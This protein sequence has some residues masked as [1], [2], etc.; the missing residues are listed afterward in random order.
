MNIV[1]VVH[2]LFPHITGTDV[3]AYEQAKRYV[4]LGHSVTMVSSNLHH[5][6]PEE[7]KDGIMIRRVWAANFLER[8]G[9]PYPLFSPALFTVLRRIIKQAD[10]VHV[11]GMLY[12]SSIIAIR[13]AKFY[14][15]PVVLTQTAPDK[16]H[17]RPKET[18]NLVLKL[19]DTIKK[20]QGTVTILEPM[21]QE[22]LRELY[23]ACLS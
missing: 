17:F 9:I 12:M 20:A 10:I 18:S 5:S 7:V 13:L 4:R 3:G 22:H 11:H 19:A 6:V 16:Y 23:Q 14:K 15:K 8:V 21:P 2:Y 1:I